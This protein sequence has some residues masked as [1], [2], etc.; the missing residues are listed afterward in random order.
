MGEAPGAVYP[1]R[2]FAVFRILFGA[3]LAVHCASLIPYAG[4]LFGDEGYFAT[5]ESAGLRVRLLFPSILSIDG[6]TASVR[7]LLAAQVVL[8]AAFA[9]GIWRRPAAILLW[10]GLT[11]LVNRNPGI[12]NPAHAF[13]GWLCL[14][15]ALV[16]SG[17]PW[18]LLGRG[19]E[20]TAWAMPRRLFQ[21]AW[22][23]MALAYTASGAGKLKSP[24]WLDGTAI[25]YVL[26]MPYVRGEWL[27]EAAAVVPLPLVRLATWGVLGTELL[28]APL[29]LHRLGRPLVWSAGVALHLA[30][31]PILRFP[32]LT[33]GMLLVHL[34]T[35]DVR[36]VSP[37]GE[38]AASTS[39]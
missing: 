6:S 16:P 38:D 24:E 18:R 22:I 20:S 8:S 3:L 28:F 11:C 14:A 27:R 39:Q 13:L 2:Q 23:V 29:S 21:G 19:E 30:L 26:G 15:S 25:T 32:E 9:A 17:E 12:Q 35:F 7:G 33:A 10:Y 5:A 31:L 36:W 1:A 34:F 37:R 4:E